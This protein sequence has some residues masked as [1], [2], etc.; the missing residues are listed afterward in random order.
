M[1]MSVRDQTS[2]SFI[3]QPTIKGVFLRIKSSSDLGRD[4]EGTDGLK[5]SIGDACKNRCS[6]R[7]ADP[8][9]IDQPIFDYIRVLDKALILEKEKDESLPSVVHTTHSAECCFPQDV[10]VNNFEH[11][12]P[13]ASA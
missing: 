5:Y 2:P 12:W 3:S 6:N 11:L 7:Y 9:M 10:H 1:L 8:R 4:E 13:I